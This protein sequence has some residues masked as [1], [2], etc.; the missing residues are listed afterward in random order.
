MLVRKPL[1]INDE[2]VIDGIQCTEHL[3]SQPTT[4][5]FQLLQ[6]RLSEIS[7]NMVDR[8]PLIMSLPSH[9][10]LM[11]MDTELQMLLNDTPP[12]FSMSVADLAAN[13]QLDPS[14]ASK[15]AHQGYMFFSLLY[16]Q[17]CTFHI[18]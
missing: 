8:S 4:M 7:H 6:L 14:R 12:F 5:S 10:I 9:E 2:D 3:L 15:I 13:Y 16:A 1:N 11:G 18:P 17:R